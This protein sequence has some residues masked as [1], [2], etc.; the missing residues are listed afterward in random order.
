MA[1]LF[2]LRMK[3]VEVFEKL[4]ACAHH[5]YQKCSPTKIRNGEHKG[6]PGEMLKYLSAEERATLQG[7]SSDDLVEE[8]LPRH[9]VQFH[10]ET[11]NYY[12]WKYYDQLVRE[13]KLEFDSEVLKKK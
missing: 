8:K 7:L 1:P 6:T 5:Y 12:T 9:S 3:A 2:G 10:V 13:A 4:L 11:E